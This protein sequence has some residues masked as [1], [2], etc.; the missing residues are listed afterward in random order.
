LA[1]G[2]SLFVCGRRLA[3]IGF[4]RVGKSYCVIIFV[5]CMLR[6][7]CRNKDTVADF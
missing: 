6:R 3:H 7:G 5:V 1:M 4:C 2:A